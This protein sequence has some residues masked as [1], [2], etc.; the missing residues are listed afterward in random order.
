MG[1]DIRI[2]THLDVGREKCELLIKAMDEILT[3]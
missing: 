1:A 3:K 2:V